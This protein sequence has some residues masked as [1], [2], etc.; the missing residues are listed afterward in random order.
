MTPVPMTRVGYYV[1][2]GWPS[3]ILLNLF[4]RRIDIRDTKNPDAEPEIYV[5][6]PVDQNLFVKFQKEIKKWDIIL[7][8]DVTKIG[9]VDANEASKLQNL[10]EIQNAGLMLRQGKEKNKMEL[11]SSQAKFA[12]T[13]EKEGRKVP[14]EE[15]SGITIY[16]RSPHAMLYYLGE[17]VRAEN[18]TEN[19]YIPMIDVSHNRSGVLPA[20][21]FYARKATDEDVTPCVS[22][23]YEGTRYVIPGDPDPDEGYCTDRSMQVLSLVSQLIGL[24]KTS[25][26]APAT[27]VVS[28][29]GR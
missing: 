19:P 9:E 17:I 27:G 2:L 7:I 1:S 23:D 10:I 8:D 22:V 4:I 29:I 12:I 15:L 25:E 6:Y 28:V 13:R 21:L 14:F 16:F 5:N 24:Q 20:R 18:R 26:E 3:E 11:Y